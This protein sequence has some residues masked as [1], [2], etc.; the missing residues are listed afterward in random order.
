MDSYSRDSA[1]ALPVILTF[2]LCAAVFAG[3]FFALLHFVGLPQSARAQEAGEEAL[4][5]EKAM[6]PAEEISGESMMIATPEPQEPVQEPPEEE[7]PEPEGVPVPVLGTL[8]ETREDTVNF[9]FIGDILFDGNYATGSTMSA[10]G[11]FA[12]CLDAGTRE[13]M[14]SAD[15]LVA[16]NEFTYTNTTEAFPG[17]TY[18]FRARPETVQ[19][20]KDAG[21]DLAALANNHVFDFQEQGLLDTLDTLDAAGVPHIGAG[22]DIAEAKRP[23]YY[24]IVRRADSAQQEAEA[25]DVSGAESVAQDAETTESSAQDTEAEDAAQDAEEGTVLLREGDVSMTVAVLNANQIERYENP[26][27]RGAGEELP[28]VFRCWDPSALYEAVREAKQNADLCIVFMHW[29]TE[30]ESQPDWYQTS[31]AQGLAEAGADLI[32]GA[33]PH[34]LQS[35]DCVGG[36]PVFYSLG[37]FLFTSFTLDTGLLQ[38]ELSPEEKEVRNLR[39]V[40]MLQEGCT[41]RLL[42]GAEKERVLQEIRDYSGQNAISVD[43]DGNIAWYFSAQ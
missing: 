18:T 12:N 16:N 23:A 43:E 32:V 41:V 42:S 24:T 2:F 37:N 19:W 25:A 20:L 35:V 5:P 29:G 10:R 21:V 34:C 14:Q 11:G 1:R 8:I 17:K 4:S 31:Q 26:E 22:R 30:K 3:T 9:S 28:G 36:V 40:P 15:V 39:F 13:L 38:V 27:T 33:H 6:P 7:T